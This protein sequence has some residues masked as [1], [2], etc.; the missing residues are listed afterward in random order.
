[1]VATRKEVLNESACSE[2]QVPCIKCSG[3][4]NHEVVV[5]VDQS[6]SETDYDINWMH[7]YQIIRCKG[8]KTLSYRE[9]SSTSED[10]VQIGEDEWELQESEKLFPSRIEGRKDLGNDAIHLPPDLRRIYQET[11]EA[12]TNNSPVLVG[13]GLRAIVETVCK[14]KNASGKDLYAKINDMA[15]KHVLTPS[16]AEIL[17]KVRSLGNKAAHEVKPHT[18]RQLSLAMG[19]V[20]HMLKDVYI[21]PKLIQDEF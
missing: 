1:M 18:P 17:H 6:G 5:S 7:A 2:V 10:Y 8:C 4:T 15:L 21:L 3:R 13:I 11:A 20:E 14:E 19:V 16:G 12:L 9:V